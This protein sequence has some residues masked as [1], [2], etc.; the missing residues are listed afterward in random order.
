MTS[1]AFTPEQAR[2]IEDRRG[3]LLLAAGAGSG[4]T[5]VLVERLVRAVRED[6][7]PLTE[8][9]AITFTEKAAAELRTR[10]QERFAQLGDAG[11]AREAQSAEISTIHA[12]CARLLRGHALLAGLDPRFRV[13]DE[14]EQARLEGRAFA[15]A[16]REVGEQGGREALDVVAAYGARRLGADVP[17]LHGRLR[18]RGL[19]APRLP[20][21]DERPVP[22]AE[23]EA[24]V[25]TRPAAAA[26]LAAA[27]PEGSGVAAGLAA[28]ERC[29]QLLAGDPEVVP[30]AGS[31]AALV[32]PNGR[33]RDLAGPACTA[34][35]EA[36]ERWA[37]ACAD[38][39]AVGTVRVLDLLLRTFTERYAAL[40][41]AAAA[42][43]FD[44]LELGARDL[45]A[46]HPGV[47]ER[48]AGR[49]SAILVDEF[50][51]TNPV[52]AAILERLE[53][54]NLFA[55]GDELQSIYGFRHAD[56]GVIRE[57]RDRLEATGRTA[58][59]QTNFRSRPEL[60]AA[61]N[62][63]FAPLIG[64]RFAPLVAGR[65]VGPAA[66]PAVELLVTDA[67]GWEDE[68]TLAA[69]AGACAWR[70][71]EAR[72]LGQR[73]AELV[74][75]EGRRYADVVVLLRS[76]TD[77]AVYERGLEEAGV[78][79]YAI[80]GRGY[81]SQL[82][83][84]DL[85][86]YLAV[87][88]NPLDEE[89]LYQVLASPLTGASSDGLAALAASRRRAGGS[90]W[91]ALA[92]LESHGAPPE[93]PPE[94]AARL[95]A[96]HR[97]ALE[98]RRR[99]PRMSLEALI[100]AAAVEADYDL[101]LLG[102]PGGERR[103]ANVRKLMRL[104]REHEASAGR[105]LRAFLDEAAAR[106]GDRR[107]GDR[108]SAAPVEGD[109]LDA[110]RVMTIHRAKGLEFPVVCLADLGRQLPGGRADSVTVGDDG[111]VGVRLMTLED[112]NGVPALDQRDLLDERRE[113]EA[114]EERRLFW[115]AAT[116][117]RDRLVLSGGVKVAS[118]PAPGGSAPPLA[119]LGP[120]FAPD[121]AAE[122]DADRPEAEVMLPTAAGPVSVRCVLSSPATV[123]RVLRPPRPRDAGPPPPAGTQL[124]L[125]LEPAVG[126]GPAPL[127]APPLRPLER[128]SYSALHDYQRC[129]YRFHL[130][131]VLG[132]PPRDVPPAA[133]GAGLPAAVRGTIVHALLE[134]LDF[135]APR[136]PEAATVRDLAAA[137]GAPV[138]D[139]DVEDV[140]ALVARFAASPLCRRLAEARAVRRETSFAFLL[141]GET[142]VSGVLDVAAEEDGGA[143]VVDYKSD[144]LDGLSPA[145]LVAKE[146]SAQQLVY[147][148]AALREGASAVEVV[149]CL[150]ER[151]DEPVSVRYEADRADELE[152]AVADLARGIEEE[153]FEVTPAP[154]RELC[155]TCP[156]RGTLCSWPEEVVLRDRPPAA[157]AGGSPAALV[158]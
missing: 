33:A 86:A 14:E 57:R 142:V 20:E 74:R 56:V 1:S 148:L 126:E 91:E 112:P 77:M 36:L 87:L 136:A 110:V 78:P 31:L 134:D 96:A 99:A 25:R 115:V 124:E 111:R 40:K 55:V 121:L 122:L 32:L 129:G 24:V 41:A 154:H 107:T 63:A 117:A 118:W 27:S 131:R 94:D 156:G 22:D 50:Q 19:R 43:D 151:A 128:V 123:G 88:A 145:E 2:A 149:H 44:D 101:A 61:L 45:L 13:L 46:E 67:V 10:V 23:R 4:K 70:L 8:V 58:R 120:A 133:A 135:A 12:F 29:E 119:W 158:R 104:A 15:A 106:A 109:D 127:P 11:R 147:A 66:D 5:S 79:A 62:A 137:H 108:E 92:R 49:F 114:Q 68:P 30:G 37:Q 84:S 53:R 75:Q 138:A 152:R 51:D 97:R 17:A 35:R 54:D 132:L 38:H 76:T 60:V 140:L 6:G 157:P 150:L 143:L 83:V 125:G 139:A 81:W 98:H 3:S 72:L 52:Q 130:E 28:L 146:Y 7:V 100:E 89:R 113:A 39:R 65:E 64:E 155:L 153:R 69:P 21:V 73:V 95:R 93:M 141:G 144:R 71:A 26:E 103:L 42:L 80:G 18:S 59:L 47:C 9:L 85:V 82:E 105:D 34:Y 16:L 90:V 116:R 48:V 102:T